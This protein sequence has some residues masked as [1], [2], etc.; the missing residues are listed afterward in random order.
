MI[1]SIGEL[2]L[3]VVVAGGGGALVALGLFKYLGQNWI[4]HQLAKDLELAKAEISLLSSRRM[5]LHDKE[6]EVFPE[7]WARLI[8]ASNSL[9]ASIASFK[10][11]P[12]FSRMSDG[13]IR[14][15]A[16]HRDL[17][18]EE[19]SYFFESPDKV[20]AFDRIIEFRNI[21]E[22][23]KCFDEFRQYLQANRIFL[24]PEI[25]EKFDQIEA[26]LRK[27]WA[28]K[29]VDLDYQS[30]PG[31]TDFLM[32][33]LNLFEDEVKPLMS[34]LEL[35]VQNKLLPESKPTSEKGGQKGV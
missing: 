14:E 25:K 4:K 21:H 22:A 29:K 18:E 15:W 24:S 9:S 8:K 33:A 32:K 34:E 2:I 27:S 3:S 1:E 20:K 31:K 30:D 12:D 19:K 26:L 16:D 7:L 23:E 11:M 28:A 5:E 6:Y 17:T 13:D 10:T 35:L